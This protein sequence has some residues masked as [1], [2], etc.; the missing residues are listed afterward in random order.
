L[1]MQFYHHQK[2]RHIVKFKVRLRRD[3]VI[4][5]GHIDRSQDQIWIQVCVMLHPMLF[6]PSYTI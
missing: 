3:L 6:P 4:I 2:G 5:Q 1:L